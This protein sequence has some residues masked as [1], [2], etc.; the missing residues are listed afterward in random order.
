[1]PTFDRKSRIAVIAL[2][3]I[4]GAVLA[5]LVGAKLLGGDDEPAD[6]HAGESAADRDR[7]GDDGDGV[8]PRSGGVA[9][10]R[11]GGAAGV[12]DRAAGPP[13]EVTGTVRFAGSGTT[14]GTP[15]AGA[16]V[17]FM[18]DSGEITAIADG[19]GRYR[20]SVPSGIW[21]KVHA[22]SDTAVGLPEPFRADEATS[23]DLEVRPVSTIRGRV[24]DG[25]GQGAAGAVVNLEV[26]AGA[27]ALLEAS[28]ALSTETDGAG[29]FELPSLP[30][31]VT[32]RASRGMAQ[33]LATATVG[34]APVEVEVRLDEPVTVRGTVRDGE[35][36]GVGGVAVVALSTLAAG[37]INEKKQ[38]ATAVDGTFEL[39]MPA[40]HVRL[41]ARA[42]GRR[43]PTW[44]ELLTSGVRRDGVELVLVDELPLRGKVVTPDGQPVIAAR[45][46]LIS[47][48]S[49][50]AI[51][52]SDGTFE[53][54]VPELVSYL[55]KVRHSAGNAQR[56]VDAW[57]GDEQFVMQP[58]GRLEVT[59]RQAGGDVTVA[60][61]GFVPADGSGPRPPAEE[62]YHGPAT[63]VVVPS[64]EAGTYD[65][66]VSSPGSKPVTV[67]GVVV[68]H[69]Q[70]ALV[71]VVF[72][73]LGAAAL[74][75]RRG[76]EGRP[77]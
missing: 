74:G 44:V 26:E 73:K 15:V 9:R 14:A 67:R 41:E 68:G 57:S 38:V 13:V 5:V 60:I 3:A 4:A 34:E 45:V 6:D 20:L 48:S 61:D 29:R 16:E 77:C 7:A 25:R 50:D 76:E 42:L 37:G 11:A 62:R 27:R 72:E 12:R 18:N 10:R 54:R 64:L 63:G 66:T 31:A 36:R 32:L 23:R 30:G 40:G 52:A 56:R 22:R 70:P 21:W 51:T 33:G 8:E 1:M 59:A 43:A 39:V 17:A 55:V 19:S 24:V 58:F 28:M 69:Q 65:L 49:Y 71:P 2:V 47:A 46:R 53:V 75:A 35:G